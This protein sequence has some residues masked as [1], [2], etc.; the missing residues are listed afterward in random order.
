MRLLRYA[1]LTILT[2]ILLIAI[3]PALEAR[4]IQISLPD[5]SFPEMTLPRFGTA[6]LGDQPSIAPPA[7]VAAPLPAQTLR[8]LSRTDLTSYSAVYE[9]TPDPTQGTRHKTPEGI[10]WWGAGPAKDAA[11]GALRPVVVLLHG[12]GRT[13][14]S[15][16]DMWHEVA[17]A[18]NI[19]LIA[20]D[21]SGVAG[22]DK[23]LPDPRAV[24]AMLAQAQQ[25]YAADPAQMF[26]FG[27]SRGGIAAQ[28]WA[29]RTT[30][31]WQAAAVHAGTLPADAVGPAPRPVPI[32]HY[33][34][35]VDRT[36]PFG[37]AR[38]GATAMA[39]A[40]HPFDLVRLQGHNHWFYNMG[41]AIAADAWDWMEQV[42]R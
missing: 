3:P 34:G 24:G 16:I 31:P 8:N 38:D 22:W 14:H 1:L 29:N 6:D 4:G 35:S 39:Q 2:G 12:A 25:I 13:G 7:P 26:L 20:P 37:P 30:A 33:L 17:E 42:T 27:H 5:V 19:V 9:Y 41:E 28:V 10:T 18:Q 40:G 36:F 21:L 32:R 23:G 11:D 15:M